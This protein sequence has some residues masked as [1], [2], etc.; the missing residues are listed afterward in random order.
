MRGKRGG[1]QA[2]FRGWSRQARD[3]AFFG[4]SST[5]ARRTD[6]T[7]VLFFGFPLSAVDAF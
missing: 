5:L 7:V 4:N 6:D 3:P 2:S 1:E